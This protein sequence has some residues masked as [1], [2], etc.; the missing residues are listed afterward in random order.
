MTCAARAHERLIEGR[1]RRV[2]LPFLWATVKQIQNGLLGFSC[3]ISR[4]FLIFI[5]RAM[6]DHKPCV[7]KRLLSNNLHSLHTI[8]VH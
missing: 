3:V 4:H 5:S 8:I 7:M 6:L 1:E 2:E